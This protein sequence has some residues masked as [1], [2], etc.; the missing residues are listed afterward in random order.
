VNIS[1]RMSLT[2]A[3]RDFAADEALLTDV[4]RRRSYKRKVRGK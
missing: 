1:R 4:L 3:R 2:A